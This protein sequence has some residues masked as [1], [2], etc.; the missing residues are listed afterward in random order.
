MR[1]SVPWGGY[2]RRTEN[3]RGQKHMTKTKETTL[4]DQSRGK[5]PTRNPLGWILW[6]MPEK[7]N[8]VISV[9]DDVQKLGP[10]GPVNGNVKWCSHCGKQ[11]GNYSTLKYR[12][13]T[14]FSNSISGHRHKRNKGSDLNSHG[15]CS[16]MF[17]AAL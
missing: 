2:G 11:Y 6:K 15:I 10:L 9:G 14:G 4:K 5:A 3:M 7:V 8:K 17:I 16:P 12:I 1:E 13:T